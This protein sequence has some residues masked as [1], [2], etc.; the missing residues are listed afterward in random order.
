MHKHWTLFLYIL[1]VIIV[2]ELILLSLSFICQLLY[3]F[4]IPN[5]I[6]INAIY[7]DIVINKKKKKLTTQ[8]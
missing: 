2:Y 7:N 3:V 5:L 6:V 1:F 8:R 4:V